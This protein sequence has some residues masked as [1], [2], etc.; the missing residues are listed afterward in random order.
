MD[1]VGDDPNTLLADLREA[2]NLPVGKANRAITRILNAFRFC[3]EQ[4]KRFTHFS[5]QK[6]TRNLVAY[7]HDLSV[8]LLCWEREQKTPIHDH[9]NFGMTT[10]VKVLEGE[11][12][13]ERHESNDRTS[14]ITEQTTLSQHSV[15]F[16]DDTI[17]SHRLRNKQTTKHAISLHVYT[18]P[19]LDCSGVPAVFCQ[20]TSNSLTYGERL[21]IHTKHPNGN[22]YSNFKS[23]VEI[24]HKE[25]AYITGEGAHSVDRGDHITRLLTTM[26]FNQQEWAQYAR[27]KDGRYTQNLV[28]YGENFTVALMCWEK[29]QMSPIHDHSGASCWLKVL[30]GKLCERKY[31]VRETGSEVDTDSAWDVSK[32]SEQTIDAEQV[33]YFGDGIGA[34]CIGNPSSEQ[35]VVSL[36]IYS[37][38]HSVCNFYD[39]DTGSR[40]ISSL[41]S[42]NFDARNFPEA[43]GGFAGGSAAGAVANEEIER[44]QDEDAIADERS[45]PPSKRLRT[46]ADATDGVTVAEFLTQLKQTKK[47]GD[48]DVLCLLNQLVLQPKAWRR[49]VQL[50]QDNYTRTLVALE[51]AFSVVIICWNNGQSSPIHDHGP[52]TRSWAK[53]LSGALEMRT[54]ASARGTAGRAP[55]GVGALPGFRPRAQASSDVIDTKLFQT[56]QCLSE[57]EY[58]GLHK[59]GNA[60]TKEPAISLHVYSPPYVHCC[61]ASK[62]G[63]QQVIPVVHSA[64]PRKQTVPRTYQGRMARPLAPDVQKDVA[65]VVKANSKLKLEMRVMGSIYTD[66]QSCVNFLKTELKPSDVRGTTGILHGFTFH[67]EEW[68]QY[69]N[70]QGVAAGRNQALIAHDDNFALVLTMWE[71]EHIG[72][73]HHHCGSRC[74][75]KVLQGTLTENQYSVGD[76]PV[77]ADE[78]RSEQMELEM[79]RNAALTK[80]SVTYISGLA[81]HSIENTSGERCYSLHL[82]APP[83]K[84]MYEFCACIESPN[85]SV[86]RC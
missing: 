16:F 18:P 79:T 44:S 83:C 59:M 12:N 49:Y 8:L 71:D 80:D 6:Y 77:G 53:V 10:W 64:K 11:L 26:R 20:D 69:K 52:G 57:S 54:Y 5:T 81:V 14:P 43:S 75:M 29:K 67:P 51:Q 84:S 22:F 7:E 46:H 17:G 13:F 21:R 9:G 36:H 1:G 58:S 65:S 37:P 60:S 27:F 85:P 2:L 86:D 66:F 78:P 33:A 50:S 63:Q 4:W 55:A 76:Q 68:Q 32:D 15:L 45:G 62:R 72:A 24:L 61:Y 23:L 47:D 30:D 42:V 34:H 25:L 35:V 31:S 19:M 48:D 38:P 70:F 74:W 3:P 28:G 41:V 39:I 40:T 82:F 73:P 56:G